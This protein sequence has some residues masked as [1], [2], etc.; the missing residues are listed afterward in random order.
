MHRGV[1]HIVTYCCFYSMPLS[2]MHY[3]HAPAGLNLSRG[4]EGIP[5]PRPHAGACSGY[6]YFY[7]FTVIYMSDSS[8]ESACHSDESSSSEQQS[9]VPQGAKMKE[10][11]LLKEAWY[12]HCSV[13]K[14]NVENLGDVVTY[15]EKRG[16]S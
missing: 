4:R 5:R 8:N 1:F 10:H 12:R 2:F 3:V 14:H 15:W 6:N 13:E 7:P 11:S 9:E 16:G